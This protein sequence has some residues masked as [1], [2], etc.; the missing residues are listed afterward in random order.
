MGF[1]VNPCGPVVDFPLDKKHI[2]GL[3][4]M[5]DGNSFTSKASKDI[6]RAL[7]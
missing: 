7:G 2:V 6:E 1:Q 5:I 4:R 3:Q